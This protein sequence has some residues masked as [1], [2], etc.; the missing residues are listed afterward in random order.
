MFAY[1]LVGQLFFF[2]G[3]FWG[4]LGDFYEKSSKRCARQSLVTLRVWATPATF[5]LDIWVILWYTCNTGMFY[6]RKVRVI[7]QRSV[8]APW[9]S[10]R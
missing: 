4:F 6:S 8:R 10:M 3:R 9:I 2:V 5:P 7:L 1:P